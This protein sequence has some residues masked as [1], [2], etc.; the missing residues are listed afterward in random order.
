MES[1][2]RYFTQKCISVENE[3]IQVKCKNLPFVLLWN[4]WV[5]CWLRFITVYSLL[6]ENSGSSSPRW[7]GGCLLDSHTFHILELGSN[8]LSMQFVNNNF[9]VML[10]TCDIYCMS[11][12]PGRR[13]SPLWLFLRFLPSYT[14]TLPDT[15]FSSSSRRIHRINR[16][17]HNY[18]FNK[19]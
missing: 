13:I 7:R 4:T 12:S 14:S 15:V 2:V 1:N 18:E 9:V 19:L 17:A 16:A 11:A 8:I 6:R 3:N 5:K 10:S